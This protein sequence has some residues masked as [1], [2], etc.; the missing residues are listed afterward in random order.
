M[1]KGKANDQYILSDQYK[2]VYEDN[3]GDVIN[4]SD[5]EDLLTAYDVAQNELGLKLKFN[6]QPLEDAPVLDNKKISQKSDCQD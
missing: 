2:I 3:N 6:I 1:Y 5:D 4:V